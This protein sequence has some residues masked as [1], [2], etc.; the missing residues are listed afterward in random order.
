MCVTLRLHVGVSQLALVL[1][2][3]AASLLRL[4]PDG[5]FPTIVTDPNPMG[6]VGQVLH[7]TQH[8]IASVREYAR[9]QVSGRGVPVGNGDGYVTEYGTPG[10]CR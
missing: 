2:L 9:G 1:R 7:P 8:R 3:A 4:D 5:H 10:R 6:K